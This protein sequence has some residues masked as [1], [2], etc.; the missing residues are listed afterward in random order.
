MTENF[1]IPDSLTINGGNSVSG[2]IKISGAK[3]AILGLMAAAVL[4]DDVVTLRNVP[5]ITDVLEMGQ[6]MQDIGVDVSF[7]PRERRLRLHAAKIGKNVI[8]HQA[9]NFRA[10]YYL[11]GSLL[12]RFKRTGEYNNLQVC[13]LHLPQDLIP[14][15]WDVDPDGEVRLPLREG[16]QY[17]GRAQF[18]NIDDRIRT[19]P[20]HLLNQLNH[21]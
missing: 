13:L 9:A 16:V 2:D 5:Y 1:F 11:W 21:Q 18:L 8:S 20:P 4:T 3:N 7:N 15:A 19:I 12:A 17:L 10:S 14:D 6:I